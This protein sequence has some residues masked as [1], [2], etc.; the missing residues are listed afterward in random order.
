MLNIEIDEL[1]V[2]S[3]LEKAIDE[4][5]KEIEQTVY[6]MNSKEVLKYVGM[7]WNSFNEHIMSDPNFTAAIRLGNKWLFNRKEL[8]A[9]LEKFFVAVRENGGDI[10]KYKRR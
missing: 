5:V 3:L 1:M 9:Y 8:D 4:R 6:F 7:S 2:K 10:Q